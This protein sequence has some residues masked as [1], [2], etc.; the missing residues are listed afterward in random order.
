MMSKNTM[1]YTEV[2]SNI[3]IICCIL[4]IIIIISTALS[5]LLFILNIHF[6]WF[7]HCT[8]SITLATLLEC[9]L[10][11]KCLSFSLI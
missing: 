10:C 8:C 4:L 1:Q 6:Y 5:H 11:K 3:I 2:K 7:N 9:D